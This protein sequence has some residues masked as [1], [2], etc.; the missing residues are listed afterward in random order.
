MENFTP[1]SALIGGALIGASAA[2]FVMLNGRVAGISG[3]LG[4]LIPPVRGEV[5]WRVAFLAG[6]FMAPLA[7]VFFGGSLPTVTLTQPLALLV[8][9]GLIV[10]FG[11]RLGAGCTSGHGV[12]GIGRASPRS[13]AATLVFMTTAIATILVVRHVVG[14]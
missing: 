2:L 7:Y 1:A 5:A 13:I 6:L 11:T 14:G 10:G 12:C 9:A 8:V 4:G 3:V